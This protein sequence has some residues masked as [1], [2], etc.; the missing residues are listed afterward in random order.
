MKYFLKTRIFS[1][2]HEQLFQIGTFFK[3]QNKMWKHKYFLK[4]RTKLGTHKKRNYGK[5]IEA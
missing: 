4:L 2:N 1:E 5:E 3:F